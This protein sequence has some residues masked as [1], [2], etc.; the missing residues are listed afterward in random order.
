MIGL[1][2]YK[3]LENRDSNI[4]F[5]FTLVLLVGIMMF[6]N[7][8]NLIL[9]TCFVLTLCSKGFK[10]PGNILIMPYTKKEVIK[11]ILV[12]DLCMICLYKLFILIVYICLGCE[13]KIFVDW[14]IWFVL[15][16]FMYLIMT[17]YFLSTNKN[18][19]K[20]S[21][22]FL[23]MI[24]YVLIL[25]NFIQQDLILWTFASCVSILFGLLFYYKKS[26]Q[27]LDNNDY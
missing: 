3:L 2:R 4:K 20:V 9:E 19:G 24:V 22:I 5:I 17:P 27:I 23:S 12:Y 18:I 16:V 13:E 15:V 1:L 21:M 14:S 6:W 8:F 10:M 11:S 25:I 26:L 7:G